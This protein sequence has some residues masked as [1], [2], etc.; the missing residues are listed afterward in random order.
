[1]CDLCRSDLDLI[2]VIVEAGRVCDGVLAH[3]ASKISRLANEMP[4][5][6]QEAKSHA[7]HA[8]NDLLT[9]YRYEAASDKMT[10]WATW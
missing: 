5:L 8:A 1:M 7:V 3:Y 2:N 9:P 4:M 10:G 6:I